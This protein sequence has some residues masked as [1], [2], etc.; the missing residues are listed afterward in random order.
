[1]KSRLKVI[2]FTPTP[3]RL[4]MLPSAADNGGFTLVTN[5]NASSTSIRKNRKGKRPTFVE[6][7]IA[8]KI[9]RRRITLTE[10]GILAAYESELALSEYCLGWPDCAPDRAFS[11]IRERI[12]FVSSFP[13]GH[14]MSRIGQRD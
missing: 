13:H 5:K 1:M 4:T 8:E 10:L 7:S 9:E 3:R 11:S 2:R 6:K 14:R 12:R